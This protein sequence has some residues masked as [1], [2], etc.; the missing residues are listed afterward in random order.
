MNPSART[1]T[2]DY[3]LGRCT[4]ELQRA[5]AARRFVRDMHQ[6]ALRTDA[7]ESQAI[8]ERWLP[9]SRK[10]INR[11]S[12]RRSRLRKKLGMDPGAGAVKAKS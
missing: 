4:E 3:E 8:I 10:E 11:L 1:S 12:A 5:R 2:L 9:K 6:T 7:L